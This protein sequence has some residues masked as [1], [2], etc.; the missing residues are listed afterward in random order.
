MA[1]E[2]ERK[3][4]ILAIDDSIINLRLLNVIVSREGF[5]ILSANNSLDAVPMAIQH[6][7]DLILLDVMMPGLN[8]LEILK[9][10][11]QN[12]L[13][14][15]IP[16]VMVTAR[17]KGE[18]VKEALEKGAFDYVKKPLDE[19]EIMARIRSALRYKEY[20]DKLLEMAMRDSLTGLY[21]HALLIDLLDKELY[22]ARRKGVPLVFAMCDIDHFKKV[23]DQH[24]HQ[25]GD[26]VLQQVSRILSQ[27]LRKGDPIGRYGGEEFGII[28]TAVAAAQG[29]I[30][31][32]R[33]RTTV[34]DTSFV[35]NGKTIPVTISLGLVE[36]LPT[37]DHRPNDLIRLADEALYRAKNGGRNCLVVSGQ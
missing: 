37:A 10:L 20:Q 6:Q 27:A 28:L 33:I 4:I 21:N 29:A 26:M 25:A 17:T 9:I 12:S 23:N 31:C 36:A 7:P 34:Q 35:Y 8:G 22:N 19:V 18:D 14:Q 1:L 13:T 11:K 24:G 32:D 15:N 5:E 16:V 2:P 30:L 3:K